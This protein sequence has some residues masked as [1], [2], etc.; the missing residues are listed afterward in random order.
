LY[1]HNS[2]YPAA[3]DFAPPA[4]CAEALMR[5]FS[6]IS[7]GVEH[8]YVA[9]G[10]PSRLWHGRCECLGMTKKTSPLTNDALLAAV[11]Q[12]AQKALTEG[13]NP[14]ELTIAVRIGL[15][16]A[17]NAGVAFAVVMR[18]VSDSAAQWAAS[19]D[20][21]DADLTDA[22]MICGTTPLRGRI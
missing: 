22:T 19:Q 20:S 10:H 4:I 13:C 5:I 15:D 18:A 9:P 21:P 2:F 17:P 3:V 12:F 14:A 11:D 7:R 6:H 16:L 1:E 8:L